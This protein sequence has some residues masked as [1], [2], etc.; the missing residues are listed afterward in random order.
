MFI[1]E[2]ICDAENRKVVIFLGHLPVKGRK[3]SPPNLRFTDGRLGLPCST[4]YRPNMTSNVPTQRDTRIDVF[5]ALALLT[6]F[7]NHVPG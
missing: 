1:P 3:H 6:I 7:I 4:N 2:L 5:R